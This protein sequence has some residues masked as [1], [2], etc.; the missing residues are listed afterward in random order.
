MHHKNPQGDRFFVINKQS[1]WVQFQPLTT[2][3]KLSRHAGTCKRLPKWG[4]ER[5]GTR[6]RHK[7]PRSGYDVIIASLPTNDMGSKA[8]LCSHPGLTKQYL[9]LHFTKHFSPFFSLP[10]HSKLK[11]GK[12]E[13]HKLVNWLFC[14][15]PSSRQPKH[16]PNPN[17]GFQT[18]PPTGRRH[19]TQ[20]HL[21]LARAATDLR[22]DIHT[23]PE[24]IRWWYVHVPSLARRLLLL[25]FTHCSSHF[26]LLPSKSVFLNVLLTQRLGRGQGLRQAQ[27]G[28]P[29]QAKSRQG[30]LEARARLRRRGGRQGR[31]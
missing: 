9:Y 29:L 20:H 25:P 22:R 24:R 21:R 2:A 30:P 4:Q 3:L 11:E 8:P 5:Q 27:A 12:K 10:L 23:P 19:A 14:T 31:P 15:L 7:F 18:L 13:T 16:N 26:C 6:D 28:R 1:R 17:N